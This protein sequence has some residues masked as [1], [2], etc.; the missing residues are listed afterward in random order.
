MI[1][2][3]QLVACTSTHITMTVQDVS[4]VVV[5]MDIVYHVRVAILSPVALYVSLFPVVMAVMDSIVVVWNLL[6]FVI[7][8]NV[9]RMMDVNG[10]KHCHVQVAVIFAHNLVMDSLFKHC[11]VVMAVSLQPS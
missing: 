3:P 11:P 2:L 9:S 10:V 6:Q 7:H 4:A 1:I 5:L 8:F